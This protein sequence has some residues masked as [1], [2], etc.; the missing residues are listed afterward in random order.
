M[1]YARVDPEIGYVQGMNIICSVLIYHGNSLD[2]CI[3]IFKFLMIGCRFRDIFM[4]NFKL[5]FELTHNL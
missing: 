3:L 4:N 2:Q 1:A 5:A